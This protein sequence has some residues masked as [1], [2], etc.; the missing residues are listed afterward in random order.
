MEKLFHCEYTETVVQVAQRDCAI[1]SS[2]G[3]Q[4]QVME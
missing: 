1:S 2:G 3:F 4:N